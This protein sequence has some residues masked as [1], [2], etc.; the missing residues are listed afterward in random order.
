MSAATERIC[1][2]GCRALVERKP[3]AIYATDACKTRQ[4]KRRHR[5]APD[6]ARVTA[7]TPHDA[8]D[9]PLKPSAR[10]VLAVLREAGARGCTTHDLCQPHIGG[11]RFGGRLLELRQAGFEIITSYERAGSHRY[12]LVVQRSLF[13][14]VAA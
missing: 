6:T 8:P 5:Q 11:A 13:A 7:Q 12:Q 1:A 9:P 2:C 10:R 3:G 14:E 4:W